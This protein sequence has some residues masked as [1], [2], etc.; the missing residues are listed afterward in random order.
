MKIFECLRSQQLSG[1]KPKQEKLDNQTNRR[2]NRLAKYKF[3][4]LTWL[5]WGAGNVMVFLVMKPH[6]LP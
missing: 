1:P 6:L 3:F 5:N 2:K 4:I